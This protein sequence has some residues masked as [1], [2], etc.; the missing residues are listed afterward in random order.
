M[1]KYPNVRVEYADQWMN[2]TR[3]KTFANLIEAVRYLGY[4]ACINNCKN[5]LYDGILAGWNGYGAFVL[6]DEHNKVIDR[7]II[8]NV[9]NNHAKHKRDHRYRR[10]FVFRRGPVEGIGN[11]RYGARR[12]GFK[13]AQEIRENEFLQYDEDCI[14]YGIKERVKRNKQ[15][16]PQWYDDIYKANHRNHN[17]KQFRNTQW[18]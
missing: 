16:M 1:Q 12:R 6:Y 9:A 2:R 4:D 11:Y 8:G 13:V 15:Y 7:D 18:K 17:W 5:R 14:E 3:G 10:N